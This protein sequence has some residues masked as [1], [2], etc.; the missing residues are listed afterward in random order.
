[1]PLPVPPLAAL[2]EVQVRHR[3]AIALA[4]VSLQVHSG[5]VLALLG[6]NG[7]GKTTAI[8]VLLGLRRPDAG[9]VELLGGDPQRRSQ[10][11][12]VGV[13][14]Q[15]TALPPKLRVGELV[16]Q[17]RASY[18]RPRPLSDCLAIAG[19]QDLQ[20]RSYGQLSG[21]Q[22]RRV[23]F[24]IALCGAPRLLFLDEPTTG[25]DIEARQ[26]MWQA[27]GQ[28]RAEG[29]GIVLTT[30]YLEE[31]E[32]LAGRVVV[33]EQGRV[34]ADGPLATFRPQLAPRRIHCRSGLDVA[35][36]RGWHGVM[37]ARRVGDQLQLLA[38]PA[39]PVV[40]RLL[41]EDPLLRELDVRGGGLAEAFVELT[42]EV[43]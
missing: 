28:L 11:E 42:R 35:V 5:E 14:L 30:H 32:A 19:V 38:E 24:S 13:M 3:N 21:G 6:R 43:A 10:R 22:Q 39:E 17:F 20:R 23:Q 33:L 25:L 36:V 41:A 9:R 31:A 26:A 37:E 34:L 15:S 8:A 18:P 16:E 4:G 12:Q 2:H 1:M 40:A 27:I 7:A 29:C